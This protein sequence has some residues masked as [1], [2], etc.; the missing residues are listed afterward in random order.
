VFVLLE[1]ACAVYI[2]GG[3]LS[4]RGKAWLAAFVLSAMGVVELWF[5]SAAF[6]FS[7]MGEGMA[8]HAGLLLLMGCF[9][10]QGVVLVLYVIER[11]ALWRR[12]IRSYDS[13]DT[14]R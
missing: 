14:F 6:V 13:N 5:T 1:A 10:I 12:A 7:Y 2:A 4:A 8:D 3:L 9:S 11:L